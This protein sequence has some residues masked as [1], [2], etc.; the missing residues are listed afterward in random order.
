MHLVGHQPS[1]DVVP[2]PTLLALN[3]LLYLLPS[4]PFSS[5]PVHI[6]CTATHHRWRCPCQ[7]GRHTSHSDDDAQVHIDGERHCPLDLAKLCG[8]ASEQL[9][10][11]LLLP[12]KRCSLLCSASLPGSTN[13]GYVRA[14]RGKPLPSSLHSTAVFVPCSRFEKFVLQFIFPLFLLF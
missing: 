1:F 3:P 10:R 12:C 2:R 13:D 8:L 9:W 14:P 4:P 5:S 7:Q 11:L 6:E